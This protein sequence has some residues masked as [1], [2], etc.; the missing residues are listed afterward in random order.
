MTHIGNRSLIG[1]R[2]LAR[3][4]RG[5]RPGIV[6]HVHVNWMRRGEAIRRMT[7][8]ERGVVYG[9]LGVRGFGMTIDACRLFHVHVTVRIHVRGPGTSDLAVRSTVGGRDVW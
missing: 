2:Q 5:G 7:W 1:I 6:V 4:F 9:Q 3:P 8:S